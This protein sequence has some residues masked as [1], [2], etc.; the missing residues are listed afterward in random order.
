[1]TLEAFG[2]SGKVLEWYVGGCGSG[3]G[4]VMVGTGTPLT[5]PQP[6]ADAMYHARWVD[7]GGPSPCESVDVT[8]ISGTQRVSVDS[9]G[10]QGNA[11]SYDPAISAD[12]RYVAFRSFASNLVSGDTNGTY[13]VFVRDRQTATLMI[14]DQPDPVSACIGG[15]AHSW[16]APS[17]TPARLHINGGA[18]V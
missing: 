9:A 7:G 6:Q 5:I 14:S 3:F 2:G 10:G 8:V 1:M 4:A 11:D 18:T 15:S 12:G 16:S 17:Q 13:D